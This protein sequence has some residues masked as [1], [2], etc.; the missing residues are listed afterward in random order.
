MNSKVTMVLRI[1]LGLA[2]VIF[3]ANKFYPFMPA[4][5]EMSEGAANFMGALNNTGY[6]FPLIGAVEVVSGLL[7]LLKKWVPFALVLLAPVAVNIVLFH[8]FLEPA[9]IAPG[10]VILIIN[11]ILI[12]TYWDKYKTLFG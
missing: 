1:L 2:L 12:Y 6:M 10:L 4:P 8:V 7:L 9:T 11:I 3:G 5:E